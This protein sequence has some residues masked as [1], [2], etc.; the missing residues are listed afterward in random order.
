VWA[1]F[2]TFPNVT[3]SKVI[4]I[5]VEILPLGPCHSGF[6]KE[7]QPKFTGHLGKKEKQLTFVI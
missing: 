2:E 5:K 3:S 7:E 1:A 4:K 6:R